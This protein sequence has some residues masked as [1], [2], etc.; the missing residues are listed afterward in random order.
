MTDN[1]VS[2][3]QPAMTQ[4][5]ASRSGLT[6]M[7]I[8]VAGAGLALLAQIL[9]SRAAGAD[10][11]GRYSLILVWLLLLGH[12][13]TLGTNPLLCRY[14]AR[15]LKA[16]DAP[17]V[18]GLLRA[19]LAFVLASGVVLTVLALAAIRFG[20]ALDPQ[21]VAIAV[22]AL[23]AVPLLAL[24]DFLEAVARGMDRPALGV[25]PTYLVRHIAIMLGLGVLFLLGLDTSAMAL[26]AMTI[27]GLAIS[28]A[29]Q[30]GLIWRR[31]GPLLRGRK[32]VYHIAEWRRTAL[33]MA[34]G[35]AADVLFLNADILIL[36]MFVEPYMV[37]WYFAATRIAQILT[38]V[39][40][41]MSAATAQRMAALAEPH[42]R[43][44]LQ[45]L[46]GRATILSGGL[47]MLG[48]AI[49]STFA[50]PLLSLFGPDYAGGA[51]LVTL[52][53]SGIA[54]SC[55]LGPGDDVLN[56]LGYEKLA[57]FAMFAALACNLALNFAL[58]PT[59]GPLGAA[60]STASALTFRGVMTAW[61]AWSRM[62]LRLP[63]G[64]GIVLRQEG[65]NA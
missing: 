24:Q 36:G 57:A 17:A 11:F 27:A 30:F 58:I 18:A 45:A 50:A 1:A 39:P 65:A 38:Y 16:D 13:A 53:C 28:L 33:P 26:M 29:I 14:I 64:T 20:L 44:Q 31:L 51:V 22:L 25:G 60:F 10:E 3:A 34:L 62:R 35:E 40:Y 5:S 9:A 49:L 19:T 15:Y 6:V 48:A 54:I 7:A 37:A 12:G 46:I 63:F 2:P 61:F 42:E 21:T 4:I 8:R 43:L 23:S 32:P 55:L 41:G 52:L 47:A 56:M 59:F